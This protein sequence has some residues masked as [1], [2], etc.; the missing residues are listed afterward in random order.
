MAYAIG[1]RVK[2]TSTTTGTGTLDLDGASTGFRTF[3]QEIGSANTT[4]YIITDG[5]SYEVGVGTVTSGSPDTLSRD[6]VLRTSNGDTTKIS[7]GAGTRDVFHTLSG[8]DALPWLNVSLAPYLGRNLVINGNFDIWQRQITDTFATT[9]TQFVADRWKMRS[10]GTG[11]VI[12]TRQ[13]FT[14]GQTDV[15]FEPAYFLRWD[16][17]VY[18]S[19]A[20]QLDQWIEDVRTAAGQTVTLSFYAKADASATIGSILLRQDFG[21]TGS[22]SGD[23]DKTVAS[24][25]ALTTSWQKFTYT[26]TLDSISGKTIGTDENSSLVLFF[27]LPTEVRTTDFAQV[28]LEIGAVATGFEKR[29]PTVELSLCQRFYCK[30]YEQDIFPGA[31]SIAAGSLW[32]RHAVTT[33][34]GAFARTFNFPV[35][36]RATPTVTFYAPTSGNS[37][38]LTGSISTDV[39]AGSQALGDRRVTAENTAVIATNETLSVHVVADAEL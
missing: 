11:T 2:E 9:S 34:S 28:Q 17:T 19:G 36:M 6:T 33:S 35:V 23:N 15:P 32:Q 20:P 3:V 14:L 5:T 27:R 1:D 37:G 13:S 10:T 38:N 7:W 24:S 31:A 29:P 12:M 8:N 16:Q 25:V 22:P 4:T 26:V 30:T 18:T 21:T 39:A